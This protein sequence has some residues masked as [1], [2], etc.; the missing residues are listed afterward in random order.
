MTDRNRNNQ[1]PALDARRQFN[2]VQ[3]MLRQAE[4]RIAACLPKHLTPERMIRVA[5]TTIQRTPKL[6]L[7]SPLSIIGAIVQASELGLERRGVPGS[8]LQRTQQ[9]ADQA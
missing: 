7:C 8:L 5:L 1:T 2:T 9:L 4:T 3:E 6:L